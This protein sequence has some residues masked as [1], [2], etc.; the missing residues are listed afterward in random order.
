MR[1]KVMPKQCRLSKNSCYTNSKLQLLHQRQWDW[2]RVRPSRT[3]PGPTTWS[4][5]VTTAMTRQQ[6]KR[7]WLIS[8]KPRSGCEKSTLATDASLASSTSSSRWSKLL[9]SRTFSEMASTSLF[10]CK[11]LQATMSVTS[12]ECTKATSKTTFCSSSSR[13]SKLS[14]P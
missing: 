4:S 13:I 9:L 7:M 6:S 3:L 1:K 8:N 11:E 10:A 2:I 12:L 14:K 5:Q